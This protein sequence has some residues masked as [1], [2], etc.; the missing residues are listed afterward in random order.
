MDAPFN[1]STFDHFT[2]RSPGRSPSSP[3]HSQ[4]AG[5]GVADGAVGWE[6][7][8][9]I[10]LLGL[11]SV[12]LIAVLAKQNP[13]A[14]KRLGR[15]LLRGFGRLFSRLGQEPDEEGDEEYEL[16]DELPAVPASQRPSANRTDSERMRRCSVV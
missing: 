6:M 9:V 7:P 16:P 15:F 10:G 14:A 4:V 11:L 12:T 13:E 3:P 8:V 2:T 1:V 5:K